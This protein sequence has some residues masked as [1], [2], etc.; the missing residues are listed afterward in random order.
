MWKDTWMHSE[1]VERFCSIW[2]HLYED[3]FPGSLWPVFLL[4]LAPCPYLVWLRA[5]PDV[6]V[7]LLAKMESSSWGS[8]GGCQDIRSPSAFSDPWGTFLCMCSLGDLL[9][10]KSEKY[11]A[12]FS[13]YPVR[14]QL[15]SVSAIIF[16]PF[17]QSPGRKKD[18]LFEENMIKYWQRCGWG[19]GE[20]QDLAQCSGSYASRAPTS[21]LELNEGRTERFWGPWDTDAHTTGEG[22]RKELCHRPE[23]TASLRQSCKKGGT[24]FLILCCS[25]PLIWMNV[26]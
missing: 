13:F 18:G 19:R 17:C 6:H 11:V 20:S 21:H 4:S 12:T 15:L 7:H 22:A 1:G 16:I 8:L 25:L 2:N 23:D 14:A 5:L 3:S 9:D 10:L 26:I 24:N